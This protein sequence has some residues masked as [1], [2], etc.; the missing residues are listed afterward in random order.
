MPQVHRRSTGSSPDFRPARSDSGPATRGVGRRQLGGRR[1]GLG[2]VADSGVRGGD[3]KERTDRAQEEEAEAEEEWRKRESVVGG[4][5]A[6]MGER[7]MGHVKLPVCPSL[8]PFIYST[9]QT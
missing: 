5:I 6:A 7:N 9:V 2:A 4:G 1:L 8:L 3:A